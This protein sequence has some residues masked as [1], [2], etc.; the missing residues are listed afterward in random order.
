MNDVLRG[1][2]CLFS[3][4]YWCLLAKGQE[5][6]LRDQGKPLCGSDDVFRS[7]TQCVASSHEIY[8]SQYSSLLMVYNRNT[9]SI[10]PISNYL[11]TG[12]E[13]AS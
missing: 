1:Q 2:S 6:W 12:T 8:D 3:G 4:V 13:L 7:N 11:T 5:I 9:H 10:M